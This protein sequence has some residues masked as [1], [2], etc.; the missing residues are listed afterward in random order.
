[1][2]SLQREREA[3]FP[4][5]PELVRPIFP[6]LVDVCSCACMYEAASCCVDCVFLTLLFT[7]EQLRINTDVNH[8]MET[9]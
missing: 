3:K 6:T 9:R 2:D 8:E 7:L 4:G 1:M 5:Y